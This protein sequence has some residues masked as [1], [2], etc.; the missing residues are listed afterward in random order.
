[1]AWKARVVWKGGKNNWIESRSK[2]TGGEK[3]RKITKE[4]E[5]LTLKRTVY[6]PTPPKQPTLI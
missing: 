2:K 1:M 5:N 4:I 6:S 3:Y